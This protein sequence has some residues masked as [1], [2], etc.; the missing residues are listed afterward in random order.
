MGEPDPFRLRYLNEIKDAIREIVLACGSGAEADT[1]V[2]VYAKTHLPQASQ[3]RFRTVVETELANLHEGNF[4]RYQIRPSEFALWR[5]SH[6][7]GS[8]RGR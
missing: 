8:A 4:A 5:E 1:Q 3:V 2:E 7:K 6:P